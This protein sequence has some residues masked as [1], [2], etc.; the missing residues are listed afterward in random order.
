MSEMQ[1][2][3]ERRRRATSIKSARRTVEEDDDELTSSSLRNFEVF[4]GMNK[5]LC[6]GRLVAGPSLKPVW[7]TTGLIVVPSSFF[8]AFPGMDSVD[9]AGG[10]FALGSVASLAL[11]SVCSL[12]RTA[13]MDPGIVPRN[14]ALDEQTREGATPT[15]LA[16]AVVHGRSFKLKYCHTCD[17]Y[18][19]PRTVHCG[20][21]DNC[22]SE[23]DH[24]CPWIGT[25]VA[26]RNYRSFCTFV[27]LLAL[28][29]VDIF[30]FCIINMAELTAE[31]EDEGRSHADAFLAMLH[32]QCASFIL[33]FIAFAAACFVWGL[34]G[35][36]IYLTMAGQTTYEHFKHDY[37]RGSPYS[38]GRCKNFLWLCCSSQSLSLIRATEEAS[39][40]PE[41]D[42][43]IV[44]MSVEEM[45]QISIHHRLVQAPDKGVGEGKGQGDTKTNGGKPEDIKRAP[46]PEYYDSDPDVAGCEQELAVQDSESDSHSGQTSDVAYVD[47]VVMEIPMLQGG[48]E[49]SLA[50]LLPE[51]DLAAA[52]EQAT[53]F[54]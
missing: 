7:I 31:F 3:M 51:A 10:W 42:K 39:R 6:G 28:L 38:Y 16:H 34:F 22:V 46:P 41:W 29:I 13:L 30:S 53:K 32:R 48:G 49:A 12:W 43:G 47:E 27:T 24:H 20:E 2:E 14:E 50:S 40:Y 17:I 9:R 8:M 44:E 54:M 18:R 4:P 21:C 19:P 33:V 36:H 11:L 45:K 5:F 52:I 23:F 25:C 26:K 15:N 37:G 35:F 1:E